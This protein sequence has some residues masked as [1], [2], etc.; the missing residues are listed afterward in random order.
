MPPRRRTGNTAA[1]PSTQA[2]LRFG[3]QSKVSKPTNISTLPGKKTKD[4]PSPTSLDEISIPSYQPSHQ[5]TEDEDTK[6]PIKQEPSS[7]SVLSDNIVHEEPTV[8]I[9]LP[10]SAEDLRAEAISSDDLEKYWQTEE[11]KRRTSRV[12]Q[13]GLSTGEK[14]L[15]HFDLSNEYGPC[16]GISRIKR[17]RRAHILG[18]NPPPEVLSVLL[19][20]DGSTKEIAYMDELLA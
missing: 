9:E 11:M 14:I 6:S 15:R 16:I 13:G 2:T 4:T 7:P 20:E 10:K 8:K 5:S 1:R 12:H 17:W 19:K 18:L 3:P